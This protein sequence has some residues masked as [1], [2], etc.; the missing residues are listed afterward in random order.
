MSAIESHSLINRITGRSLGWINSI[1]IIYYGR[2]S[3]EGHWTIFWSSYTGFFWAS[4]FPARNW[5]WSNYCDRA[6]SLYS[7]SSFDLMRLWGI[8]SF[9][10]SVSNEWKC[11]ILEDR[12]HICLP[13]H[14]GFLQFEWSGVVSK[15]CWAWSLGWT[16]W[17]SNCLV[18]VVY[19]F[20]TQHYPWRCFS[21]KQT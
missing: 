14:M 17:W 8:D 6:Y 18:L 4:L 10:W 13:Q 21:P 19:R 11:C 16:L 15:A 20:Q 7:F 9:S 1:W 3:D 5:W 12:D 2:H